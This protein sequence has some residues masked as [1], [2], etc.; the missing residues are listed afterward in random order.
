LFDE[1]RLLVSIARAASGL[2]G[3][4]ALSM[5]GTRPVL[6]VAFAEDN[7]LV[8]EGTAALFAEIADVELVRLV[9]DPPC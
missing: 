8:R 1:L 7:Y 9:E 5:A 4:T 3:D 2:C 6:R